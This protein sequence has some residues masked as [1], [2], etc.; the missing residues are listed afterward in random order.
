MLEVF[1]MLKRFEG[2]RAGAGKEG[3]FKFS[4]G[5]R[6]INVNN[7]NSVK[8]RIENYKNWKIHELFSAFSD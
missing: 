1:K 3:H 5:K 4:F 7:M 6:V 8:N 2:I